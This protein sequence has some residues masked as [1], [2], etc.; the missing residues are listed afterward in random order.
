MYLIDT[1]SHSDSAHTQERDWTNYWRILFPK[2]TVSDI[3]SF[4]K[5]YKG[6]EEEEGDLR[7]AYLQHSGDM[8]KIM[9]EVRQR[10]RRRRRS[11]E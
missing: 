6:S 5:Q 10:R 8:D 4:E 3:E 2:V 1:W 9:E 11:E 7:R